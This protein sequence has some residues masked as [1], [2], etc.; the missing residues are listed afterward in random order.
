MLAV[1]VLSPSDRSEAVDRKLSL[2]LNQGAEEVWIVNS[3]YATLTVYRLEN[4]K[5]VVNAGLAGVYESSRV[6][7]LS[8][9][10]SEIF[11]GLDTH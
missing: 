5:H 8:L 6:P 3:R 11:E 2:S 10:L 7:G 1:E 4:G 9:R